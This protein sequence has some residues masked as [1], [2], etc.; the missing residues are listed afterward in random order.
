[1]SDART[2]STIKIAGSPL[3]MA[4]LLALSIAM[5]G[6]GVWLT[7]LPDPVA[8]FWGYIAAGFFGLCA[9]IIVWR[10]A[11]LRGP[12]ITIT[13]EGIRDVRV[14]REFIPWNAVYGISTWAYQHQRVMVLA[15]DPAVEARLGLRPIARWTRGANRKLGADGLCIT[16]QGVKIGYDQLLA[17]SVKYLN[18]ARSGVKA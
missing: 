17:T 14:A 9:A 15:V 18:A 3:Q 1:M 8:V 12:V 4:A 2:L 6:G 5:T 10:I 13:P 11:A 16:A 7:F